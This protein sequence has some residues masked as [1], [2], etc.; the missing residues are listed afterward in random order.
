MMERIAA[1]TSL[2]LPVPVATQAIPDAIDCLASGGRL[3]VITFHSLEDRIVK[4]AFLSAAGQTPSN[5]TGME[6]RLYLEMNKPTAA[7][8]LVTKKPLV[9]LESELCLN[10]RS[11]SAK[12]RVVEKL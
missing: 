6:A 2:L 11:R 4:K 3:A 1:L 7:V 10:A 5:L 8:K 9:A 12:L